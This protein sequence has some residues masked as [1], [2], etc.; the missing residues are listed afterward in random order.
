MYSFS[1]NI[2]LN[3]KLYNI[4]LFISNNLIKNILNYICGYYKT[5]KFLFIKISYHK[6]NSG[7]EISLILKSIFEKHKFL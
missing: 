3:S 6:D 4:I 1:L 7:N 2:F 5:E